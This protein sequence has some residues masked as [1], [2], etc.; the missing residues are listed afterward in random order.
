MTNDRIGARLLE[1]ARQLDRAGD[2]LYR[3]RAYRHA[4]FE[5]SRI[6]RPLTEVFAQSGR[7]GLEL[8]PVIGRTIAQTIAEMISQ[9]EAPV[10]KVA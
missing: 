3:V 7:K 5:V 8:L 4:G 6:A 1:H 9:E 2:N 10:R